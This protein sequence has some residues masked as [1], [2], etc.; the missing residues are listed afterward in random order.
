MYYNFYIRASGLV[1]EDFRFS[2]EKQN[3]KTFK[4]ADNN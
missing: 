1:S 2:S 3:L 4:V